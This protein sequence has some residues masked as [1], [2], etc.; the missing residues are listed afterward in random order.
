M[1]DIVGYLLE[2]KNIFI[3]IATKLFFDT[4]D[5]LNAKSEMKQRIAEHYAQAL[6]NYKSGDIEKAIE[7]YEYFKDNADYYINEYEFNQLGKELL[8]NYRLSKESLYILLLSVSLPIQ[9]SLEL[10]NPESSLS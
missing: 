8:E 1:S 4:R 2:H 10:N 3:P 5:R 9:S 7:K 6:D